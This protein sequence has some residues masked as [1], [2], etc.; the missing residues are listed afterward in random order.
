MNQSKDSVYFTDFLRFGETGRSLKKTI[1]KE[2]I[3]ENLA[4]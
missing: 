3:P 2:R 1:K 4:G